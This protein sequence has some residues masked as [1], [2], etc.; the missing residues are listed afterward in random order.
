MTLLALRHA[1]L[2]AYAS[3]QGARGLLDF[4]DLIE[5]TLRCSS[6]A[7][8]AWV[9]YKLD[10]GI[11]HILVDEAQDT[12]AQ[13]W[14]ILGGSPRISPPA[15]APRDAPR[16]FFAVGDEKQSIYSFQGAAPRMFAAMRRPFAGRARGAEQPFAEVALDLSFRSAGPVL[17]GVDKVFGVPAT[18][19]GVADDPYPPHTALLQAAGPRRILGAD[20]GRPREPEPEDWLMPLDQP[21]RADPAVHWP[22]ASPRR[23]A[24][25]SRPARPSGCTTP[26]RGRGASSPATS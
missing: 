9:L 5:R 10:A 1:I 3:A 7:D 18:W 6:R 15:P 16:T 24:A 23:S 2:A 20:R 8:A 26:R 14:E 13:Q 12:S 22:S 21:A 4:D 19:A 17:Q 25:G 11:D